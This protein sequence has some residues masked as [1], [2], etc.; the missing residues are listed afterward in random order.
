MKFLICSMI[1]TTCLAGC[2]LLERQAGQQLVDDLYEQSK[3]L[4]TTDAEQARELIGQQIK[5]ADSTGYQLG[6]AKAY[7]LS[8]YLFERYYQLDLALADYFKCLEIIEKLDQPELE[9]RTYANIGMVF[10]KAKDYRTAIEYFDQGSDIAIAH[11]NYP[12]IIYFYSHMGLCY[13]KAD[14]NKE[15]I[16]Y[17]KEALKIAAKNEQN[18]KL[19][20]LNNL[21][22][23]TFI[24][25]NSFDS[26]RHYFNLAVI[27]FDKGNATGVKKAEIINNIGNSYLLQKD[28]P[29]AKEFLLK[30]LDQ[31][32]KGGNIKL[33]PSTHNNLG[34][35]ALYEQDT[36][37]ALEYFKKAEENTSL[38]DFHPEIFRA[39]INLMDVH[40][41]QENYIIALQYSKSNNMGIASLINTI[42][43]LRNRDTGYKVNKVMNQNKVTKEKDQP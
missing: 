42:D 33:Y 19:A 9:L 7:F 16:M 41:A 35:I 14:K 4:L 27:E 1:I 43:L 30:A 26:A 32:E 12:Q 11:V 31:K 15:A 17:Y 18:D 23:A 8:S 6:L 36:T 24:N 39:R 22:G 28:Y 10:Y 29:K 34:E 13:M 25:L 2:D 21:T 37:I 38:S 5:I 20:K 3:T 40:E